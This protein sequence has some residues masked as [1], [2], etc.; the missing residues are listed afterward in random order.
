MSDTLRQSTDSAL[1]AADKVQGAAVFDR[2]GEPLGTVKN[3]YIDKMSGKA[4][5]A[6]LLVGGAITT[7]APYHPVPW[8][9]L[10]YDT[11][12]GGFVIPLDK[13]DLEMA[14]AY[15]EEA[16]YAANHPWRG[17]VSDYFRSKSAPRPTPV[18]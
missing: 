2:K 12:K 8:S 6:C 17:E 5:Y 11:G 14:P 9:I 7:N 15:D 3:I 13:E 16:L 18:A 10:D 4:E 1:I